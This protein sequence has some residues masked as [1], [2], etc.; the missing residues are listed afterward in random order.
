MMTQGNE[1][2]A[3]DFAGLGMKGYLRYGMS[4]EVD[5]CEGCARRED[6]I[7]QFIVGA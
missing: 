5:G 1:E 6:W 3:D 4:A 7:K 2:T